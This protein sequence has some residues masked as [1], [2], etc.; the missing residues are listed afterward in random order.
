MFSRYAF[1]ILVITIPVW[2]D[3]PGGSSRLNMP[4]WDVSDFYS[5]LF[6][7]ASTTQPPQASQGNPSAA[8]PWNAYYNALI[9]EAYHKKN[10]LYSS[11]NLQPVDPLPLPVPVPMPLP[12]PPRP[13]RPLRPQLPNRPRPRPTRNPTKRSTTTR[14]PTTTTI[15]TTTTSTASSVSVSSSSSTSVPTTT[16]TVNSTTI[17]PTSNS[18][19]EQSSTT[20]GSSTTEGSSTIGIR[21]NKLKQ[22]TTGNPLYSYHSQL[23]SSAVLTPTVLSFEGQPTSSG[24]LRPELQL[25]V[26]SEPQSMTT[27][28]QNYPR[29]CS[30]P[31]EAQY[32]RLTDGF[33]KPMLLI[34]PG[35]VAKPALFTTTIARPLYSKPRPLGLRPPRR[36]NPSRS[37]YIYRLIKT[38]NKQRL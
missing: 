31:E 4:L 7:A 12:R 10:G 24:S 1:Y 9:Q 23:Q 30:Q 3:G 37:K 16:E 27:L 36:K 13:L 5:R 25:T 29:L 20:G 8:A 32:V 17:A 33:G 34:S 21:G 19:T 11:S 35:G 18:T 2:G 14:R 15:K 26:Q 28:C 22:A 6:G 38:K